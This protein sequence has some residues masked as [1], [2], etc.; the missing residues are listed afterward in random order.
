MRKFRML[1][2]VRVFC[3]KQTYD[4]VKKVAGSA[5]VC[6]RDAPYLSKSERIELE[7]IVHL[8]AGV[9]LVYCKYYWLA[10]SAE[11]VSDLLVVVCYACA[12][13]YHEKDYRRLLDGKYDL[14]ADL[15]LEDVI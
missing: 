12:G 10:A 6:C 8:F 3:R 1:I 11:Y 4:F 9:D 5:A 14:L 2:L 7:G 13:L 15:L